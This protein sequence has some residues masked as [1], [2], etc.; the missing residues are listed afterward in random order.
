[1]G[2]AAEHEL[3]IPVPGGLLLGDLLLPPG[4]TATVLFVNGRGIGRHAAEDRGLARAVRDHGMGAILVDLL[5]VDEQQERPHPGQHGVDLPRLTQRVLDVVAWLEQEPRLQDLALGLCGVCGGG[6]AALIAGARLGTRLRALVSIGGRADLAG[7]TALASMR[8]STLLLAGSRDADALKSNDAA[9]Q[10]LRCERS[11]AVIP[12]AGPGLD[13][14][15][16]LAHAAE[17]AAD[18]YSAHF[19]MQEETA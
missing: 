18:W 1:M 9:Y 3:R 13:E 8:A 17:M 14:P 19:V 10:H 6:A 12:G 11:E 15:G 7:P 2:L 16:A 5:T 4:A